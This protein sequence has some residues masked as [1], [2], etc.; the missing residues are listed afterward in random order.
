MRVFGFLTERDW[1]WKSCYGNNT[2]GVI[3]FFLPFCSFCHF[4]LFCGAKF[5][6]HCFC[7]SR[8]IFYS[9]FFTCTSYDVITDLIC[10]IQKCQNIS[11][12]NKDILKRKTSFL[13]VFWKAF[14]ISRKYFSCHKHKFSTPALQPLTAGRNIWGTLIPAIFFF[15]VER[16][17]VENLSVLMNE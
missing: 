14:Q 1:S 2:K 9:V 7:I 10:I 11:E 13:D 5:Q 15:N 16:K 8:D 12:T 4:V 17:F 3:L 6:E